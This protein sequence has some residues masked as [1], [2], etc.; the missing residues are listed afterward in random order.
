MR[1]ENPPPP[2]KVYSTPPHS[3][4][5]VKLGKFDM[6]R[7]ISFV[8]P[9][10]EFKLMSY[11]ITDNVNLPFRVLP[12][13]KE[14]GRT[15][16]EINI[17]VKSMFTFKLFATNVVIKIPCPKNTAIAN[18]SAASG[19]CK[20]DPEHGGIIWKLRRFPGDTEYFMSGEVEIM[21]S[22]SEKPWSRPPITMDFQVPMFASSGLHVRF[23]KVF[24]K[25]NYQT[26]KWVRYITKAGQYQHR[27]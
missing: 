2:P 12:V 8:P 20:Y 7:T 14:L 19:K 3:A 10:G 15:R 1:L 21:S 11:R 13:V 16:L 17:K 26:I 23:L 5:C 24:E 9:D 18:V 25:S 6:D 22:V 27:I 4:Q